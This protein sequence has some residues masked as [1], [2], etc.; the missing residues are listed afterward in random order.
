MS[1]WLLVN[2]LDFNAGCGFDHGLGYMYV[3]REI[4]IPIAIEIYT[5]AY[6]FYIW[7]SLEGELPLSNSKKRE[8]FA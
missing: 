4:N 7:K 1:I 8:L 5:E 6:L 3:P 2:R